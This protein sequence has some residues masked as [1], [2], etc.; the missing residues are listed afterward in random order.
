MADRKAVSD[1]LI[2]ILGLILGYLLCRIGLGT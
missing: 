1:I 2:F